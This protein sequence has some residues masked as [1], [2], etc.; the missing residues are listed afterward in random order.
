MFQ[1]SRDAYCYRRQGAK[2]RICY[3][4]G[5]AGDIA[6]SCNHENRQRGVTAPVMCRSYLYSVKSPQHIT[7]SAVDLRACVNYDIS[8]D[9]PNW[10]ISAVGKA[11][12][13]Q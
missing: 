12:N 2:P 6:K 5:Q 4:C 1:V 8:F 9:I 13:W 10:L 11:R 7:F 3:R